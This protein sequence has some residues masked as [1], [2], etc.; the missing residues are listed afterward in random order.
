MA[1]CQVGDNRP[2]GINVGIDST[3]KVGF[4][5]AGAVVQASAPTAAET[6]IT[7]AGTASDYLIQALTAS[8]PYG[9]VT[10]AE[11]ETVVEVVL[12]NQARINEIV[13]ALQAKGLMA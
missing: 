12:N 4:H 10:Q 2:D 11:G 13:T 8:S 6:T 1:E 3:E 9:F 5:G 7:N